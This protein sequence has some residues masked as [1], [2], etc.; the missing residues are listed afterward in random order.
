MTEEAQSRRVIVTFRESPRKIL[1]PPDYPGDILTLRQKLEGFEDLGVDFVVLIDFSFDFSTIS[2]K[3]FFESLV[4][5]L[6]IKR[7]V[8]GEFFYFGRKREA[9]IGFL[10]RS[11]EEYGF[12]LDIVPPVFYREERVS[13]TRIRREIAAGNM[14]AAALM[15]GKP[16][17]L[18]LRDGS[19]E[20]REESKTGTGIVYNRNDLRQIVPDAGTFDGVV[21]CQGNVAH[22]VQIKISDNELCIQPK[23][24]LAE[25]EIETLSFKKEERKGEMNGYHQ[26]PQT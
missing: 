8:V 5:A 7:L 20:G 17:T 16:H 21:S 22:H 13:S 19:R 1:S 24:R 26:R 9:G 3:T 15:L 6:S 10:S 18:D 11:A 23:N 25:K 4:G 2:A 12:A 14:E